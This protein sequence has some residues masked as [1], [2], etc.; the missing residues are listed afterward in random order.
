MEWLVFL[1]SLVPFLELRAAFPAAVLLGHSPEVS[2]LL[3]TAANMLAI[4]LAF[5]LLD[6]IV[7]WARERSNK[8]N[9]FFGWAKRR[10]EGHGN[11]TLGM[12][13]IFVAI[14]VPG[15]GAYSGSL[16]AYLTGMK[17]A[18]AWCA[19]SA[20]VFLAGLILYLLVRLGIQVI[21]AAWTA[22]TGIL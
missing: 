20:G 16:I 19:I 15:S 9:R 22:P 21:S 4:P 8:I 12:L 5:V 7:P 1:I 11:L 14:P 2:F 17:R 3:S 13:L 10:T 6:F 18:R